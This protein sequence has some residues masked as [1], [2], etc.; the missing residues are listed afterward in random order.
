VRYFYSFLSV[1]LLLSAGIFASQAQTTRPQNRTVDVDAEMA[2]IREQLKANP[3]SS[4]L[5]AQLASLASAKSDWPTFEKETGIAIK[6]DPARVTNYFGAAEVYRR[7]GLPGKASEMLKAAL[8]VDPQNPLSHFFSGVFYEHESNRD[9]ARDEFEKTKQLLAQLGSPGPGAKNHIQDGK[10][11]D[12]HGI[13]Y[14][15]GDL[16]QRVEKHLAQLNAA[17]PL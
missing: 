12:S 14:M 16:D 11:Y 6:L 5:H 13:S 17:P 7:R 15:L 10:Y 4:D 9:K 8:A 3:N 2:K 1:G